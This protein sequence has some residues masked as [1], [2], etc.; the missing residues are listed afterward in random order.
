MP[1]NHES[2]SLSWHRDWQYHWRHGVGAAGPSRGAGP[3]E[4]A[5]PPAGRRGLRV[6]RV[7][8]PG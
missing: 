7:A 3:P 6:R 4:L 8:S 5:P 2:E 1:V